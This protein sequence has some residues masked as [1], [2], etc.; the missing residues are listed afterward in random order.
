MIALAILPWALLTIALGALLLERRVGAV[1][2]EQLIMRIAEMKTVAD[3]WKT[4]AKDRQATIDKMRLDGYAIQKIAVV[5]EAPDLE[6]E[7]LKR[8]EDQALQRRS[9]R[10]FVARATTDIMKKT[11]VNR[12]EAEREAIRLRKEVD[13]EDPPT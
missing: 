9:D 8:A 11:G 13:M 12:V 6:S 10:Q 2:V 3:E 5:K 7:G 1:R 4:M